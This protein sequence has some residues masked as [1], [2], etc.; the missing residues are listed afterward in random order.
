MIRDQDVSDHHQSSLFG[1]SPEASNIIR[2]EGA[3]HPSD[4]QQS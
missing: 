4:H 3:S 2:A 1:L